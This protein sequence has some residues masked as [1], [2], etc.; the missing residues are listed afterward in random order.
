MRI[1]FIRDGKLSSAR[2]KHADQECNRQRLQR[3][4][5]RPATE[6]VQRHS[7]LLDDLYSL[8]D[9]LAGGS[10]GVRRL[11]ERIDRLARQPAIVHC[12]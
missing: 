12:I 5:A 4:L 7:R 1:G 3:R 9:P 10:E 2:E 8:V 6:H 11:V